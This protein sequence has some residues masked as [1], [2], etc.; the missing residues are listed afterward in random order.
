MREE[1]RKQLVCVFVWIGARSGEI[2]EEWATVIV[3]FVEEEAERKNWIWDLGSRW[4]DLV[5]FF[6]IVKRE[7]F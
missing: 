2:E 5:C 4:S 6:K 3:W 7:V 1:E